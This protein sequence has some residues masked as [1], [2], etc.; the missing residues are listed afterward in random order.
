MILLTILMLSV[1][2]TVLFGYNYSQ[3]PAIERTSTFEDK[4]IAFEN[5]VPVLL[6]TTFTNI[7]RKQKG[8]DLL[9]LLVNLDKKRFFEL[10]DFLA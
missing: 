5:S 7:N 9:P 6:G 4:L 2:P 10:I 3:Q 1:Y 8:Q